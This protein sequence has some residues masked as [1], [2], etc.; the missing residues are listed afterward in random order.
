LALEQVDRSIFIGC[1]CLFVCLFLG[2]FF[3]LLV[4]IYF[5]MLLSD[6]V[7]CAIFRSFLHQSAWVSL[8]HLPQPLLESRHHLSVLLG[9][10]THDSNDSARENTNI[11]DSA[12]IISNNGSTT[13]PP[14]PPR[15]YFFFGCRHRAQDFLYEAEWA[16]L[17]RSGVLSG[18]FL[19]FS[20]DPPDSID[21]T[22]TT[23]ST[24]VMDVDV[25]LLKTPNPVVS[26]SKHYVQHEMALQGELLWRLVESEKA[27]FIVSGRAD[28]MPKDVR[29][30][31]L[32]IVCDYGTLQH[33]SSFVCFFC[34][35]VS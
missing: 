7:G 1:F 31:L 20:R 10:N 14:N 27:I 5:G 30:A 25:P 34:F 28:K 6:V 26:P 15:A 11:L 13:S 23:A 18:L 4:F 32:K 24:E 33:A 16:A 29:N 22:A 2:F 35:L 12:S 9:N 8:Q 17:V 19:A 3:F 21:T